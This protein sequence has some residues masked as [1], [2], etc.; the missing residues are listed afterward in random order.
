MCFRGN[1]IGKVPT[2][3]RWPLLRHVY[4][5]EVV[6][7]HQTDT[8][9]WVKNLLTWILPSGRKCRLP[10]NAHTH[11]QRLL[12]PQAQPL[13][14]LR[15]HGQLTGAW[16][17]GTEFPIGEWG[18]IWIRSKHEPQGLNE[19]VWHMKPSTAA[20]PWGGMGR[21]CSDS[22]SLCCCIS[23]RKKHI[24]VLVRS[25]HGRCFEVK[26]EVPPWVPYEITKAIPRRK[27]T[28][29]VMNP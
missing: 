15:I 17:L 19:V 13:P 12:G 25:H 1:F 28:K 16:A 20:C 10:S 18:E 14:S 5:L 2:Q 21:V 9:L 23:T 3:D 7:I 29:H 27:Q 4:L 11:P 24:C 6:N 8:L 26:C 22:P